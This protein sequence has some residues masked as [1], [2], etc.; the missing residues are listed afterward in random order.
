MKATL[1]RCGAAL[2]L[3]LALN[4]PAC[5]DTVDN[6]ARTFEVEPGGRLRVDADRGSIEVTT[7]AIKQV[8]VTV[9][10]TVR[11][12]SET[13]AQELL[14]D[15]TVEFD[16]KNG[17]V[18]VVARTTTGMDWSWRGPRLDVRFQVTIPKA[19]NVELKTAG[20]GIKAGSL[21]GTVR[22]HTSGGSIHLAEVSGTIAAKTSGGS[23]HVEG[24]GADVDVATSGGSLHLG[25]IRGKLSGHT[26]GGSIHVAKVTGE[27][28]VH[29]SGGRIEITEAA[30]KLLATT[31]GGSI[32]ATLSHPP[33]GT[34]ELRTSGGSIDA[35][36]PGESKLDVDA[37]TSGGRVTSELPVTVQGEIKSNR[38]VGQLHGGGP[39]LILRTSG[40]N[41]RLGTSSR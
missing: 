33:T 17:E 5:A 24:C 35:R 20:G 3:A 36:I 38:L 22:A 10:R 31:S 30:G 11:G 18:S 14:R 12:A 9:L 23:I 7:D 26:S 34:C 16:Q 8:R 4:S 40:G 2:A 19:F 27:T 29:T 6:I 28:A 25:D 37:Q 32:S 1:T 13:R 21:E 41:I 15:H 39:K